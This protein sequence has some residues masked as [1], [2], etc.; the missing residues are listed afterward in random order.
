MQC[1]C[2]YTEIRRECA[3]DYW[4]HVIGS[5]DNFRIENLLAFARS[6]DNL[7]EQ[8]QSSLQLRDAEIIPAYDAARFQNL[9]TDLHRHYSAI[10]TCWKNNSQ[11]IR[12][13][14]ADEANA[15]KRNSYRETAK[16]RVIE[17]LKALDERLPA[18]VH[19]SFK[20]LTADWM[21][22]QTK[23]GCITPTH[24]FFN[25]C[26]EFEVKFN[27]YKKWQKV[28]AIVDA[29]NFMPA[30]IDDYKSKRNLIH[31]EDMRS[32]LDRALAGD[33][34]IALMEKI[35]GLWPFALIDEFQDTDAEQFRIFNSVYADQPDS[36]FFMIGDPKQA[37]YSFRGAD[38]FTYMNAVE[39]ARNTYTLGTNWRSTPSMVNAVNTIFG[40]RNDAFV[41]DR[42]PFSPVEAVADHKK[43][44]LTI[45]NEAVAPLKFNLFDDHNKEAVAVACAS[46]IAQLLNSGASQ[47]AKING[48]FVSSGDIAVLVRSHSESQLMQQALRRAGVRSVSMPNRTVFQT[49]EATDRQWHSPV[50]MGTC[51]RHW[52]PH[53]LATTVLTL[54]HCAVLHGIR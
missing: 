50:L 18:Y 39:Q 17:W 2:V 8:L 14:F 48:A 54:S 10:F 16:E 5:D 33:S 13:V 32:R 6:P 36:G 37:V 38:V 9:A 51:V 43:Y 15:L 20:L 42:I 40:S 19:K 29:K 34:A 12:E 53:W 11:R 7:L 21:T 35:R 52:Q 49:V 47:S 22:Q 1:V 44:E 27:E 23:G 25:H 31:F 26:D 3:R 41:F 24:Q 30:A 28:A 46:D 4:R 45:E